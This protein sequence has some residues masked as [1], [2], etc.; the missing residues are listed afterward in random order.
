MNPAP[1]LPLLL[2]FLLPAAIAA[3]SA[4]TPPRVETRHF[5]PAAF[6]PDQVRVEIHLPPGYDPDA[7]PGYPVLYIHDGQDMPTVGLR[8]TLADLHARDA[9]RPLIVVAIHM[10]PDRT[11]TYGLSDRQHGRALVAETKD[12]AVG[13]RAHDYAQ[14]VAT[15][16]VPTID[17]RYNT[18]ASPDA[19][20]TLGWSL[21]ALAA[22]NLGWQYPELFARV[23]MFSPSLWQSAERDDDDAVQRTRLAQ[24]Q[25]HDG[26]PRVG[27]KLFLGIGDREETDDR[28]SDGL[29]DALDD[30]RD[31]VLGWNPDGIDAGTGLRGLAQ[32]GYRIDQDHA[33]APNRADVA[34]HLLPGGEHNQASWAKLLPAF[35][36]WA[37]TRTAPPLDATGTTVSWQDLPSAHVPARNVDIWLPPGYAEAPEARYPVLYMHDGQNLFDPALSYTGIDWGVDEAMTTLVAEG[38]ARPAIVVGIWNTPARLQEYMPRK[39]VRGDALALGGDA[40]PLP[41]ERIVSDAYLRFLVEELK[42]RIDAAFRTRPGRDDTL[43]A[44]SSMGALI[45]LYAAAEYPDVFGGVGAVSTHWPAGDGLVIDWLADHLPD[46]ATH[47]LWFDHGTATL[48]AQYAPYQQRMDAILREAGYIEGDNWTTRVYEDAEH[49]EASWRARIDEVLEFLLAD[50]QAAAQAEQG[51]STWDSSTQ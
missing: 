34:L 15:E 30:A 8:E 13:A 45:S 18:R 28:D 16:L 7:T 41:V 1:T 22:F 6:A 21:G 23:G 26:P 5:T 37:Y 39:P 40:P 17:A 50:Q 19:R 33:T 47:R 12:G 25:V 49:N 3:A 38:R 11:G 4:A 27:M 32:L 46:P 48:D 36:R 51:A 2:L 42:P 29:N 10:L 35:L 20:A 43:I 24:R 44:G 14:W 9:L 31:F